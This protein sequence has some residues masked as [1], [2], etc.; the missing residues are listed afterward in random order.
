MARPTWLVLLTAV[1]YTAALFLTQYPD[2]GN[3]QWGGRFLTPLVVP[4]AAVAAIGVAAI[5][6]RRPAGRRRPFAA[7]PRGARGGV[8]GRWGRR[9]G[10]GR[11]QVDRLY[12]EIVDASSPV[13]VTTS[14][15]LP[16][17][18]WRED[19]PWLRARPAQLDGLLHDL[20]A[21]GVRRATVVAAP[22]DAADAAA[23]WTDAKDWRGR[24]DAAP[25]D[26][27]PAVTATL[28]AGTATPESPDPHPT[29]WWERSLGWHFVAYAL[30]LLAFTAVARPGVATIDEGAYGIQARQVADGSWAY[31]EG[32][33]RFDPD[34][35][36]FPITLSTEADGRWFAYVKHPA[37]P[38]SMAVIRQV[39]GEGAGLAVLP[40]LGALGSA[41]C[42]WGL[43][44]EWN[45]RRA[46]LAFWLAAGSPH[47]FNAYVTWAHTLSAAF[48]GA[49]L[50]AMVRIGRRGPSAAAWLW[51]CLPRSR[52]VSSSVPR[53]CSSPWRCWRSPPGCRRR[54]D[55]AASQRR[56][57]GRPG[58]GARRHDVVRAALGRGDRGR[59]RTSRP[60]T[61]RGT[62]D[63]PGIVE[64]RIQ[65][66]WIC[67]RGSSP[68][69]FVARG[70]ILP[71]ALVVVVVVVI[72]AAR[73]EGHEVVALASLVATVL[74]VWAYWPTSLITGLVPG[75]PSWCSASSPRSVGATPIDPSPGSSPRWRVSPAPSLRRSTPT[76]VA[77]SGAGASSCC[78]C[79]AQ[80]R[81]PRSAWLR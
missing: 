51:G 74:A 1:L 32:L 66:V 42:A 76:A 37:V 44:T 53:A 14:D 28:P 69:L 39:V 19:L 78:C 60:L 52:P 49:A 36:Y 18:M 30:V 75:H 79:P 3:F 59:R 45:R 4:L 26:R 43:A 21:A 20:R 54:A 67:L 16:R 13:N 17:L 56:R 31:T 7:G 5:V 15:L 41:M 23:R 10:F 65:G 40:L 24:G 71:V 27:G 34:G 72:R 55:R 6:E 62:T 25:R 77:S 48:V 73:S 11:D 61:M 29:R 47:A 70:L 57:R 8:V 64:G 12:E 9:A 58:R 68:D 35:R 80:R 22:E 81:S 33:A 63:G 50:W 46:P 38:A 2:G